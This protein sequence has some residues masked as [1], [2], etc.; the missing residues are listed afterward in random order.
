MTESAEKYFT[1]RSFPQHAEREK[2]C[3]NKFVET[4]KK[5]KVMWLILFVFLMVKS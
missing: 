5:G 4:I 2:N 3:P 1:L